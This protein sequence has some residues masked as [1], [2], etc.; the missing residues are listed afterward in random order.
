[1]KITD[2]DFLEAELSMGISPDNPAFIGLADA[3]IEQ[4]KELNVKT[5]LDYG[6]GVGVYADAAHRA[7]Y[8]V[9]AC[10]IW[11]AHREFMQSRY[12]KLNVT[13]KPKTTDL[14]LF[15]EVAE[16]MTDEELTKLFK[17][18]K[19][20][21]ILFSSTPERT[22]NDEAWGH[23]NIKDAPQWHEMFA[24]FGYN[25]ERK[26]NQPTGHTYLYEKSKNQ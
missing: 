10:D 4:I 9:T 2:R 22:P 26:L 19:P 15:I 8:E 14:M 11:Q 20:K 3:T 17:K 23:I 25:V 16:H 7:G 21:Y 18:I 12:P 13:D 5:V 1:M 6:A 24:A